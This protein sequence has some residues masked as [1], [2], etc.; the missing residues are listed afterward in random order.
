MCNI[1]RGLV[2]TTRTWTA[3]TRRHKCHGYLSLSLS[4]CMFSDNNL[5]K[6]IKIQNPRL[7]L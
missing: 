2:H 3:D 5:V 1:H 4:S 7:A 6:S